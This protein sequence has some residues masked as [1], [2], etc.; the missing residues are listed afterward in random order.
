MATLPLD[1]TLIPDRLKSHILLFLYPDPVS[2]S[3]SLLGF[4]Y[5]PKSSPYPLSI[6]W[7]WLTIA[8]AW[9]FQPH[10]NIQFLTPSPQP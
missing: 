3:A 5:W 1:S 10:L 2:L 8:L 6:P 4:S 9:S 7:L